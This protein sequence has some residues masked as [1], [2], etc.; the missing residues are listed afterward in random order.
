MSGRAVDG[1]LKGKELKWFDS[2]QSNW[3]AWSAEYPKT[4]LQTKP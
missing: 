3:Y 2:I 1:K 4:A